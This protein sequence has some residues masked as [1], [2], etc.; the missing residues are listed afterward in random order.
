M[1]EMKQGKTLARSTNEEK[2]SDPAGYRGLKDQATL[3]A[4]PA[5]TRQRVAVLNGD[6]FAFHRQHTAFLETP[7]QAADSFTVRPR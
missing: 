6:I 3:R 2:F 4:W 1:D 5:R 7:Q